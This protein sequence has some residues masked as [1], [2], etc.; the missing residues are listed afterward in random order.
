MN[1]ILVIIAFVAIL[2]V[3]A[4]L[5]SRVKFLDGEYEKMSEKLLEYG[6]S[7]SANEKTIDVL[8]GSVSKANDDLTFVGLLVDHL[9]EMHTP[10]R[11]KRYAKLDENHKNFKELREVFN[12]DVKECAHAM[13]ISMKTA[14]RYENW[15]I[16]NTNQ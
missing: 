7:I 1:T 3:L 2:P 15:R 6:N 11:N 14:R 10:K 12:H 9:V 13:K 4:F 8:S 5:V 16:E